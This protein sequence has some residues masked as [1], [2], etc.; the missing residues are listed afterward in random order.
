MGPDQDH[1]QQVEFLVDTG[2]LYTF[3]SP[4]LA[5]QLGIQPTVTTSLVTADSRSVDTPLAAGYM[6]LMGREGGILV[7][8]LRAPMPLLGVISLEVLGLKVN[9]VAQ[10]MEHA[11][12]FG[13]W[14][15]NTNGEEQESQ[16][17]F[18][19]IQ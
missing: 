4:E 15:C 10:T 1:L 13:L 7:G 2:T 16:W 8:I 18:S 12:P 9:P 14:R 6:R 19:S 11:R 3:V 5:A 17:A